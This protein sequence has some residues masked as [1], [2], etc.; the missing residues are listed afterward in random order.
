[1]TTNMIKTPMKAHMVTVSCLIL[2]VKNQSKLPIIKRSKSPKPSSM[3]ALRIG[4]GKGKICKTPDNK[5]VILK[6]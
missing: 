4:G 1:M 3:I 5:K 2:Q 6:V